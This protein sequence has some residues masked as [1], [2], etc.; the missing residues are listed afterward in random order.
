MFA[1]GLVNSIFDCGYHVM[2][3][4]G[5]VHLLYHNQRIYQQVLLVAERVFVVLDA[6][7][8]IRFMDR[9]T[10]PRV[11]RIIL[12]AISR[13]S[14]ATTT[15]AL[16]L[17]LKSLHTLRKYL[18][19]VLCHPVLLPLVILQPSDNANLAALV[20]KPADILGGFAEAGNIKEIH[21]RLIV[22]PEYAV[23]RNGEVAYRL[24]SAGVPQ[25]WLFAQ[26]S[27]RAKGIHYLSPAGCAIAHCAA[28][29]QV[30]NVGQPDK[31][32]VLYIYTPMIFVFIYTKVNG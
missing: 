5:R 19:P 3:F 10:C 4:L 27:Y 18:C 14:I 1:G 23:N 32:F 6:C 15:V 17:L 21:I 31:L 28:F 8:S 9:R 24:P 2:S 25:F 12:A 30:S 11:R 26:V 13:C 29:T 20:Q 16:R 22:P 7:R